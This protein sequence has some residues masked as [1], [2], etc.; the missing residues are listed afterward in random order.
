[1]VLYRKKRGQ[2]TLFDRKVVSNIRKVMDEGKILI[3]NLAKGQIDLVN[4]PNYNFYLK[5]LF[6]GVTSRPFSAITLPPSKLNI[7]HKKEII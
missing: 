3:V 2:A 7:S 1:M 6:N 5:L 4:L